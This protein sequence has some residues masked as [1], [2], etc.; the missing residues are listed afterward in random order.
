MIILLSVM[1]FLSETAV[2]ANFDIDFS[3]DEKLQKKYDTSVV[4]KELLPPLPQS[5]YEQDLD[6]PSDDEKA[7]VQTQKPAAKPVTEPA[8]TVTSKP[9]VNQYVKKGTIYKGTKF[10]VKN[11]GAFSSST[12][13][14]AVVSFKTIYQQKFGTF[15][16]PAGTTLKAVVEN[17]HAPQL[18][19]NGGLVILKVYEIVIGG[20]AYKTDAKVVMANDKKI[21]FNRIKGQRTYIKSL[22]KPVKPAGRFMGKM[23]KKTCQYAGGGVKIVL[24]P[25]TF[26][27]GTAAVC[28]A[29]VA[30]PVVA[31][32]SKGGK[33]YFPAGTAFD[34]KLLQDVN[35]SE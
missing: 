27:A 3:V 9:V 6:V 2:F 8:K 31:L 30:A 4:E 34:F 18:S 16:L 5:Y 7:D 20:K 22:S 19:G 11:S 33:L 29:V 10:A 32:C 23:W 35:F 25:F 17:S 15:V 13:K 24:A 1:F 12:P 28:G 14:G 26:L 21:F